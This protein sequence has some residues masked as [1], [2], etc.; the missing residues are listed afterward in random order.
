MDKKPLVLILGTGNSCRSQM[1]EGF[2][3]EY[4]GDAYEVAS[5]G[6]DPKSNVHPLA[7]QVMAEAGIDISG[8]H[9]K[10]LTEFLGKATVQHLLIACDKANSNCPRIWP[11]IASRTYLPFDD[12]AKN[13]GAADQQLAMFR[14]IRDEIN[15]AIKT[16]E[17]P[18]ILHERVHALV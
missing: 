1:A 13:D 7:V 3:R 12:P 2:L 11:G 14:H 10:S 8:Q 6:I 5:A 17:P 9:P 15:Q 16:W 4:R 18:Q